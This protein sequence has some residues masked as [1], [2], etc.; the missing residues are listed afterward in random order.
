MP[1]LPAY[2]TDGGS[3]VVAAEHEAH[4]LNGCGLGDVLGVDLAD[5]MQVQQP[6]GALNLRDQ[7]KPLA[8][9]VPRLVLCMLNLLKK[10]HPH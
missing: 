6:N 4:V 1:I 9:L 8:A 10:L 3:E 5:G 7:A 2:R